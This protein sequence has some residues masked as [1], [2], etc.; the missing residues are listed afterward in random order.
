MNSAGNGRPRRR[1][2]IWLIVVICVLGILIVEPI[3][4]YRKLASQR[5]ARSEAR[6]P[7]VQLVTEP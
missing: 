3:Y 7:A 2:R 5:E 6:T 4:M 1:L